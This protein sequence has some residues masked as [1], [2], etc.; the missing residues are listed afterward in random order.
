MSD[1]EADHQLVSSNGT[2]EPYDFDQILTLLRDAAADARK[3]HDYLSYSTV[4]DIHLSSPQRYSVEE[5]EQLLEELYET[6]S[7][8]TSLVAEVGWDLPQ[9]LL[10]FVDSDFKFETGIRLAPGVYSVIKLFELLALHGNAKEL[11]LKI[12]EVLATLK[13]GRLESQL[14]VDHKFYEIKIHCIFELINSCL[15]KIHTLYPLRFLAMVVSSSINSIYINPIEK[16]ENSLFVLRRIY[17]FIRNYLP[18]PVPENHGLLPKDFRKIQ[19]DET[20][21][22]QKLLTAFLTESIHTIF[23]A[24]MLGLSIFQFHLFQKKAAGVLYDPAEFALDFEIMRR[25]LQLALSLDLDPPAVFAQT[26]K[27]SEDLVYGFKPKAT[28]DEEKTAE[29]FDVL[30]KDYSRLFV[31]SI[32]DANSTVMSNS[33]GGLLAL[34]TFEAC[35][36]NINP[37]G[38][39]TMKNAVALTLRLVVGGLVQ[40]KLLH[41]GNQ[42]VAVFWCWYAIDQTLK[43]PGALELVLSSIPKYIFIAFLQSLFFVM[44]TNRERPQYRYVTLTLITRILSCAPEDIAYSFI[45]GSLQDCPFENLKAALVG[46]FRVLLIKDKI[47]DKLSDSLASISLQVSCEKPTESGPPLPSRDVPKS[48]KFISM[49]PERLDEVSA[50]IK[51]CVE[52]TFPQGSVIDLV[53]AATLLAYLNLL[54]SLKLNDITDVKAFDEALQLVASHIKRIELKPMSSEATNIIGILNVALERLATPEA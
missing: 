38:L 22:Q 11:F 8:D 33:L 30:V 2:I 37:D 25:L 20:F 39:V 44:V 16:V 12:T 48:Q 46:V 36:E 5:R 23:K 26:V 51:G 9:L 31:H 40:P 21:L 14:G 17:V 43:E 35:A 15:R 28:S 34:H 29:L 3:D 27:A 4:L 24:D 18:P 41:R 45:L 13:V 1:S 7:A 32:V 54:I 47:V 49:T 10:P 19:D 6:L 52:E 53:K 50:V 42:D